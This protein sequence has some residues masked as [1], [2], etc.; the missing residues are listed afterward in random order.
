[1]FKY[2]YRSKLPGPAHSTARVWDSG[3]LESCATD[4]ATAWVAADG[5]SQGRDRMTPE[6]V[7]GL[8]VRTDAWDNDLADAMSPAT[9]SGAT[10]SSPPAGAKA[11]SDR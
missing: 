3:P 1:V 4:T 9:I 10:P 8:R 5:P 11:G 6:K 7:C 2:I